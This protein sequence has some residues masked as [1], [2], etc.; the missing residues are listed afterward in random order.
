MI[1][2]KTNQFLPIPTEKPKQKQLGKTKNDLKIRA[3]KIAKA[4]LEGKTETEAVK[5]AGYSPAYANSGKNVIMNNPVILK[6]IR[7]IY[8][9]GG[10]TDEFLRDKNLKLLNATEVKFF[11]EKG[12][13]TDS[14]EVDDNGTRLGALKLA[15]QLKGNLVEKTQEMGELVIKVVR[16][17]D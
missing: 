16:Y 5:Y 13:V 3:K 10:I 8:D 4:L 9:A 11:Q 17:G 15:H 12:I 6:T 14:R 7:E 2:E 1:S